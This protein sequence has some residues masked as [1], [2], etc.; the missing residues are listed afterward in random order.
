MAGQHAHERADAA[1]NRARVLAAASELFAARGAQNVTM[2]DIARRAGVG[3]ATLYRRYP[4]RAS[5]AVALLDE[6]ERAIQQQ[7]ISGAAP[8]GPGASPSA[9][10]AAFY[11]AMLGLLEQHVH[12]AL[13]AE[14][15]RS[16][17]ETG[18][19]GF[20]RAHVHSLLV[21]ADVPDPDVLA[22]VLLAP[23]APELYLYQR[24][25]RGWEREQIAR[26]L[27]LLAGRVLA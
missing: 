23:L 4:D 27:A 11:E 21:A 2:D 25:T 20:W 14:L 6:H 18:A 19:Y 1:E 24:E 9:R 5:I 10:L 8:L 12:L 13:G 7:L 3:R 15:G 17:Y 22:D 16:R 26:S